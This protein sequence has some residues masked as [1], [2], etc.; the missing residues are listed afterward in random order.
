MNVIFRDVENYDPK[1]GCL[2][3]KVKSEKKISDTKSPIALKSNEN[4][5]QNIMDFLTS[6]R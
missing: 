2:S 6:G 3:G 1:K 4:E 5:S